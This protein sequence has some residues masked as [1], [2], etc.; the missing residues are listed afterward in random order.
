[1]EGD[2]L[3]FRVTAA[4]ILLTMVSIIGPCRA[5]SHVIPSWVFFDC[6][7]HP[8]PGLYADRVRG[9]HVFNFCS[10]SGVAFQMTCPNN[11]LFDQVKQDC[12]S[13]PIYC[14]TIW[15]VPEPKKAPPTVSDSF[16]WPWFSASADRDGASAVSA[17]MNKVSEKVSGDIINTT[18]AADDQDGEESDDEEENIL[19]Q[20]TS[21]KTIT[22]PLTAPTAA[23]YR[24]NGRNRKFAKTTTRKMGR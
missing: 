10:A 15:D 8:L 24:E 6:L 3:A 18:V 22:S 5:Q 16:S 17:L 4:T 13:T 21:P 23:A 12:V 14:P 2:G 7:V 9:C 19:I 1:M 20:P 11:T